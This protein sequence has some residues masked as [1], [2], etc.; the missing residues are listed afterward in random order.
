HDEL[1]ATMI[2]VTH[3]QLEAM[4]LADRIVLL[5]AGRIE[6]AGKPTELYRRPATRFVAEFIGSPKMNILPV[7]VEAG[8]VSL[9][10][11][12]TLSVPTQHTGAADLGIRPESIALAS[13]EE[14]DALRARVLHVE[15][16]GESRIIHAS[17]G[18]SAT[19]AVR[20]PSDAPA[21]AKG[22]EIRL[23]IDVGHLHMFGQDGA[24]IG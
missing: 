9:P 6:Q 20:H 21:P 2:Y 22:D 23:R 24:R 13:A 18:D 12:D 10:S 8:Q 1:K 19:L 11:G 15:E 16:L 7:T 3:D 14:S 4:T 17:L 5:N